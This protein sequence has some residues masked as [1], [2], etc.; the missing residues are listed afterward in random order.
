MTSSIFHQAL[1][2]VPRD[3]EQNVIRQRRSGETTITPPELQTRVE[4]AG[5]NIWER[6]GLVFSKSLRQA[7][8][9]GQGGL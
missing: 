4:Q 6:D 1:I 8:V 2:T 3:D 7:E 5:W 9:E